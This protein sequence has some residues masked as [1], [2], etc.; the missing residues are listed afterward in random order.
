MA[1]DKLYVAEGN[2]AKDGVPPGHV[3]VW[4]IRNRLKPVF[5]KRFS[6]N[7]GLPASFGDAHELATTPDKRHVFAQSYRSGHLIKIDSRDDRVVGVWDAT[8]GLPMPHGISAQ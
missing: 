8:K 4:S 7:Q 2:V 5:I 6:A 3:S 1:N